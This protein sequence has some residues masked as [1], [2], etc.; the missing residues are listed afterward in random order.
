MD[1][2]FVQ[3]LNDR[4]NDKIRRKTSAVI[5]TCY[6]TIESLRKSN[7]EKDAKAAEKKLKQKAKMDKVTKELA[8]QRAI[9]S[10]L[11]SW[12]DQVQPLKPVPPVVPSG[13]PP[14]ELLNLSGVSTTTSASATASAA[15]GLRRL[16]ALNPSPLSVSDSPDM[17]DLV[18]S[19]FPFVQNVPG[20]GARLDLDS[21][22]VDFGD[23]EDSFV[24]L[25]QQYDPLL[26][27]APVAEPPPV[28]GDEQLAG[29]PPA[30]HVEAPAVRNPS[31]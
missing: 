10:R 30:E 19:Q 13:T 14:G 11:N 17:D 4:V 26:Q 31:A 15:S 18:L 16:S 25:T 8:E 21:L 27:N 20:P 1:L 5:D 7:M 3:R 2:A 9:L 22:E 28:D 12:I 29:V 24:S 6:Q 23:M